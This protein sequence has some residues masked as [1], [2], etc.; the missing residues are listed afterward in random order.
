MLVRLPLPVR[1]VPE[2]DHVPAAESM[3]IALYD[4]SLYTRESM[5]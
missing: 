3:V 2:P 4:V 1:W 5:I